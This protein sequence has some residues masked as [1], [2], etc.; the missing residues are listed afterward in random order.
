MIAVRRRRPRRTLELA[1]LPLVLLAL[2]ACGRGDRSRSAAGGTLVIAQTAEPATLF[3]PRMSQVPE[4]V[5][6]TTLFER[7]ADLGPALNTVGD[8]GFT[9]ALARSWRWADDSLSIAFVLD[10]QARWHDGVPVRAEDVRFTFHAYT[11]PVVASDART[12]LRQIDSVTVRDSLTAVFW[13]ARRTPQQFFDATYI[14][15]ILPAHL[16]GAI[17]DSALVRAPFGRQPVGSGPFR[18]AR[19][20]AG[21]RLEV[22]ADS[23]RPRGRP[24]LDRLVFSY[25][26]D[27]PAATV[28][29]LAGEADFLD[30]VRPESMAAMQQAPNVR[31]YRSRELN[32]GFVGF[33]LEAR[34]SPLG[35]PGAPHPILGDVRVR[36]ALTM[37]T[38]R[39]TMVRSVLDSLGTVALGP[40]PR[41]LIPD[42]AALR[43]LVFNSAAAAALLDSAGWT[44]RAADG[45]RLRG[46]QRL[47]FE[48]LV[49]S[50]SPT[51]IRLSVLLQAALKTIGVDVSLLTLDPASLGPRIDARD[52]DAYLGGF[53]A[54][55][56]LQ[57]VRQVWSSTGSSNY[58]GYRSARFDQLA[59]SALTAFAPAD[60]R[61][62]WTRALQ[63]AIDDAPSLWLYEQSTVIA[64]H[65][66]VQFPP[67]RPD[68]WFYGISAW[69]VGPAQR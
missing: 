42:T 32:Y 64:A 29:L 20:E 2:A 11:S 17:P 19:W 49:P 43:P 61:M 23:T 62:L 45:I 18:F 9:P 47:A 60:S 12:L 21:S 16:L 51:R 22:V 33:N 26:P 10:P 66:R 41:A 13:F 55:P 25:V 59:D 56:G 7:L 44:G 4:Q 50:S 67:F 39:A 53:Q 14:M 8:S 68:G 28:K 34:R 58:Q 57:G 30:Q 69:S 46:T 27:L 48:L 52:F 31:L 36:R 54:S 1:A 65:R 24:P 40:A 63:V 15:Y 6:V 3:P 38:D 37:A 35:T 5:V